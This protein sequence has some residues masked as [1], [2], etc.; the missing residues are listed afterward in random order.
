MANTQRA[1]EITSLAGQLSGWSPG[2]IELVDPL[3]P[4][5]AQSLNDLLAGGPAPYPGSPVDPLA[6]GHAPSLNDPLAGGPAPYPGGPVDPLHHWVYF[7]T[8]PPRTSL[9]PDGHP[10]TGEFMP[11]LRDRRR[12]FAGGRCTLGG[13]G[14]VRLGRP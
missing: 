12:M 14:G 7:H 3:A 10:R 13:G 1:A 8:W 6:P 11:P 4:G 5:H 9:A 2:S